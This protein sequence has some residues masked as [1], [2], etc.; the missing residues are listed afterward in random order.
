[1]VGMRLALACAAWLL[2]SQ[3][4]R[5]SRCIEHWVLTLWRRTLPEASWADDTRLCLAWPLH[6]ALQVQWA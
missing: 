3:A 5:A 6:A 4:C 2:H 1:M